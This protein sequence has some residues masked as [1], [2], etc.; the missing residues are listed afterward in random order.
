MNFAQPAA[1]VR[2]CALADIAEPG[3]K[4]F[5]F[6]DGEYLFIGFV[7]RKAGA[8][9]GYI[10]RCPHNGTPLAVFPDRYLTRERDLL[11]CGTHGA[12]FRIGDGR[13]IAGPCEGRALTP[14]PVAVEG[15][16]V[17]TA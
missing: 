5:V 12:L 8:L 6:R 15:E 3:A 9:F 11:L 14:W 17:V 7:V 4:T 13:C 1:G 16:A 2:L 10:D